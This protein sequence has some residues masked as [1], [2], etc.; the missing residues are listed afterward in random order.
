MGPS[1]VTERVGVQVWTG[2]LA[3]T[4]G[5]I[6]PLGHVGLKGRAFGANWGVCRGVVQ[7][8]IQ[9]WIL[10]GGRMRLSRDV[11]DFG[12]SRGDEWLFWYTPH[13]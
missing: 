4:G 10:W 1:V 12:R 11:S 7:L 8:P 2:F 13:E 5:R 9:W 6:M 3:I